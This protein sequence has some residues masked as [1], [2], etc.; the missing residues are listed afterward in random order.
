M[1]MEQSDKK[2]TAEPREGAGFEKVWENLKF[3]YQADWRSYPIPDKLPTQREV[4]IFT[5]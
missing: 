3:L 2:H 4:T 1:Y 5:N